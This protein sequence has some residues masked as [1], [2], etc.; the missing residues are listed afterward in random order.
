MFKNNILQRRMFQ[1]GGMAAPLPSGGGIVEGL[2]LNA[3]EEMPP[4]PTP[5]E[6]EMITTGV[7]DMAG[8]IGQVD[9]AED[10]ASL[11][12]AIRSD[13]L[14]LDARYTELAKYVGRADATA[15]PESVLTLVQ[16]TFELMEQNSGD[17]G[18]L[19]SDVLQGAAPMEESLTS[20]LTE[21]P[22]GDTATITETIDPPTFFNGGGYVGKKSNAPVYRNNGTGMSGEIINN[23]PYLSPFSQSTDAYLMG[24]PVSQDAF[25]TTPTALSAEQQLRQEAPMSYKYDQAGRE[26]DAIHEYF[27]PSNI[28]ARQQS[29][30]PSY[31]DLVI[32]GSSFD[33]LPERYTKTGITDTMTESSV[34]PQNATTI[35]KESMDVAG[36]H[37]LFAN[38][39]TTDI[40]NRLDALMQPSKEKSKT[41]EDLL[42]ERQ[43]FIGEYDNKPEA[44]FALA[45]SFREMAETPGNF[46]KG[47]AA[48]AGKAAELLAPLARERSALE[49]QD[50]NRA[51]DEH[52]ALTERIRQDERGIA[53][54]AFDMSQSN[55]EG[56]RGFKQ[57]L[58]ANALQEAALQSR[59]Q[60][61]LNTRIKEL[62]I[63]YGLDWSTQTM[64]VLAKT[65]EPML[66]PEYDGA[67]RETRW[68]PDLE[69]GG[70]KKI[71]SGFMGEDGTVIRAG[72]NRLSAAD[73]SYVS[74]AEGATAVDDIGTM[75]EAAVNNIRERLYRRNIAIDEGESII[76]D[77]AKLPTGIGSSLKSFST[78][79]LGA[80]G[81]DEYASFIGEE[82]NKARVREWVRKYIAAEA[83][84]DRYAMGEQKLLG[85]IP[86]IDQEFFNDPEAGFARL[87]TLVTG[88][89]NTNE[90][91][92]ALI[93]GRAPGRIEYQASAT[94]RDPM[95]WD[96]PSVRDTLSIM[97]EQGRSWT[98][99][100][101]MTP[102]QATLQNPRIN[103][104]GLQTLE[105]LQA[106]FDPESDLGK[107]MRSISA[108]VEPTEQL[109]MYDG[110]RNKGNNVVTQI[111]LRPSGKEGDLSVLEFTGMVV[112]YM[113]ENAGDWAWENSRLASI[114]PLGK[115]L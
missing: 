75:P 42:K 63:Q 100:V 10:T 97:E 35:M 24:I 90:Y 99:F 58:L 93:E 113:N 106:S 80:L 46:L 17:M 56:N 11:I 82:G 5:Q 74:P 105:E 6:Q 30:T 66:K 43:E 29:G 55:I 9:A 88:M 112:P 27:L 79:T 45:Q 28:A 32:G 50:K 70:L 91:D 65:Y 109:N 1:E 4:M 73:P 15:T 39:T 76:R 103:P 57:T 92:H 31:R 77:M 36:D 108:W 71:Y 38:E 107:E 104:N 111:T 78:N 48:G 69:N 26:Q 33:N 51:F 115:N 54:K 110:F 13:N 7:A 8:K 86:N 37:D 102:D 94:F 16:P 59:T 87:K 49:Y 3:P 98:G 95:D 68:I 61:E 84:S 89:L 14:P 64:N 12:N 96:K 34:D 23:N 114:G 62:S 40:Q 72:P 53:E 81:S 41:P 67:G 21:S 22:M 47:T 44:W 52:K 19:G 2:G 25:S 60:Q 20:T 18:M 101:E 83:L 85:E